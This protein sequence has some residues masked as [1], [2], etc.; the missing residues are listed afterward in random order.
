MNI[1]PTSLPEVLIIHPRIFE[2]ARGYFFESFNER[3]FAAKVRPGT[4]KPENK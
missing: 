1:E 4:P 3:E 2:D